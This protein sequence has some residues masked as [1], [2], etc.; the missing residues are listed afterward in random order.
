MRALDPAL[1]ETNIVIW[2]VDD[3]PAW[4]AEL[5][6]RGVEVGALG[7]HRMRAVTHLDVDDRGIDTALAAFAAVARG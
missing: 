6:A 7:P 3:A 2:E 5:A 4:A 1:V